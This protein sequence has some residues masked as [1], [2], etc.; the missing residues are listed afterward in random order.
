MQECN[1]ITNNWM[2]DFNLYTREEGNATAHYPNKFH[3][4]DWKQFNKAQVT[5]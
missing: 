2:W 1:A 5:R 3:E 4:Y